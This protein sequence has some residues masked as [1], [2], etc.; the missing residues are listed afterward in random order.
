MRVKMNEMVLDGTTLLYPTR[1]YYKHPQRYAK[2]ST[3]NKRDQAHRL[4]QLEPG[5]TC[6]ENT[7]YRDHQLVLQTYY[8]DP[9]ETQ[10]GSTETTD[11]GQLS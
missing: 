8:R 5:F 11:S 6:I 3:T 7:P 1:S 2:N 9:V 4:E 10:K